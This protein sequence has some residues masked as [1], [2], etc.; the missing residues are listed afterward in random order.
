MRFR[1]FFRGSRSHVID[2]H[3]RY[4]V[5][6]HAVL[7]KKEYLELIKTSDQQEVTLELLGGAENGEA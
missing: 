7:S 5:E 3:E 4:N 6:F 2:G 1:S